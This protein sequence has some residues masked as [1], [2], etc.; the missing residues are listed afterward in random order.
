MDWKIQ[1]LS[2]FF[3]KRR[4]NTKHNPDRIPEPGNGI[5]SYLLNSLVFHF[6]F[7]TRSTTIVPRSSPHER[8]E[9]SATAEH[10]KENKSYFDTQEKVASTIRSNHDMTDDERELP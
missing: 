1:E 4:A 7:W 6:R 8:E 3:L 2:V 5:F 9:D 10:C